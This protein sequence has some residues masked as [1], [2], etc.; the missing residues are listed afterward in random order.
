MAAVIQS[1]QLNFECA[2]N[3]SRVMD[4]VSWYTNRHIWYTTM[5]DDTLADISRDHIADSRTV[6]LV[7]TVR[8]SRRRR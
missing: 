6:Y 4:D 8:E 5:S 1:L 7:E 3:V 2:A